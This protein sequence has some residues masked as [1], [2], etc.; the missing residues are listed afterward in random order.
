MKLKGVSGHAHRPSTDSDRAGLINN[1]ELQQ[2]PQ[3]HERRKSAVPPG[4]LQD[5]S[6]RFQT[7][8][9]TS[10]NIMAYKSKVPRGASQNLD[11]EWVDRLY[12][13]GQHMTIDLRADGG[14]RSSQQKLIEIIEA[15]SD[16]G[17]SN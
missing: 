9:L 12:S 4:G 8:Q 17:I 15:R 1:E 10:Q 7:R 2:T 14:V 6:S 13:T 5:R 11:E 16:E 3:T